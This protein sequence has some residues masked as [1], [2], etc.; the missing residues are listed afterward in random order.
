MDTEWAIG[1]LTGFIDR[2]R[3]HSSLWE[4]YGL[5]GGVAAA[6][7]EKVIARMPIVEQI[8]DRAWP[9]WRQH[10]PPR[11]SGSWDHEPLFQIAIQTL[12]LLRREEELELKLGDAGPVLTAASLHPDVWDAAQSLWRSE[13]FGEAVSA[14]AKSVNASTQTK[15]GRRDTNDADLM[16]ECFTRKAPEP[17]QPRLRLM[18]DD[19]GKTYRSLQDGAGSFGR[20]CFQA[21]RNPLA[22]EHGDDLPEQLALEYLAAFSVLARWIESSTVERV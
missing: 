22:H 20:G 17:G 10:Q 2:C 21:V 19:G 11:L 12:E 16:S 9:Q 14:A 18:P 15:V 1:E 13:H 7:R 8:A 4:A 5:T 3:E 6:A